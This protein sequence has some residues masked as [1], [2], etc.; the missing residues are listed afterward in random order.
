LVD[1]LSVKGK[2]GWSGLLKLKDP[3]AV[4]ELIA[5]ME[6]GVVRGSIDPHF[7]DDFEPAVAEPAQGIGVEVLG[8][9]AESLAVVTNLEE[10]ARSDL[11]SG[12]RQGAEQ[13]MIRMASKEL[14]D[15]L[16][17]I[18]PIVFNP[19]GCFA[20]TVSLSA[21]GIKGINDH[22][23][24]QELLDRHSLTGLERN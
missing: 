21:L 1:F 23:G 4:L 22:A 10:Q 16:A 24:F 14:F 3:A 8:I 2:K 9:A 6:L 7:V 5:V 19:A 20:F 17:R 13:V 11:G 12:T 18:Q 15:S